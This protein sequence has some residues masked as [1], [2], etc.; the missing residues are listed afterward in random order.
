MSF[1]AL[2][3]LVRKTVEIICK[4]TQWKIDW[5]SAKNLWIPT[6]LKTLIKKPE[7]NKFYLTCMIW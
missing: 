4:F 2:S 7:C 3:S 5:K 6:V 1:V